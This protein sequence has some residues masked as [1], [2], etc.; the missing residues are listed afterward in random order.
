M[1]TFMKIKSILLTGL[2]ACVA[3]VS[4]FKVLE[5][6]Q[7]YESV[8]KVRV[9]LNQTEKIGA[10]SESFKRIEEESVKMKYDHNTK[11]YSIEVPKE[12]ISQVSH[13]S[14]DT[15]SNVR[16]I[17]LSSHFL[18]FDVNEHNKSVNVT[19]E[20]SDNL[21][22]DKASGNYIFFKTDSFINPEDVNS[23]T[24]FLTPIFSNIES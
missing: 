23:I 15:Y 21:L 18:H 7:S 1:V 19:S 12:V 3:L 2:V 17:H 10:D 14:F 11:L 13:K 4:F 20:W 6:N 9:S 16:N 24:I 5:T 22:I 8:V